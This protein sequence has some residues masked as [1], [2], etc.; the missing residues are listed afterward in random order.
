MRY[1]TKL[2]Y[3]TN[4]VFPPLE[5][6]KPF[7]E[8]DDPV[9]D[10]R[11]RGY[12]F[13]PGLL[14]RDEVLDVRHQ[15]M[16]IA[17]DAG[18]LDPTAPF[19]KGVSGPRVI[20]EHSAPEEYFDAYR[21]VQANES[22]H[23]LG[24][25]QTLVDTIT[26][27]A[28]QPAIPLPLKMARYTF[29]TSMEGASAT[30]QHQDYFYVQG[31]PDLMIAWVSLGD[32]VGKGSGRLAVLSGSPRLGLW[33]ADWREDLDPSVDVG[34][35]TGDFKAGDVLI[36]HCLT[37]HMSEPND[38]DTIRLSVDYRFQPVDDPFV[39][40]SLRP[41]YDIAS[42]DELYEGWSGRAPQH[43]WEDLNLSV[44]ERIDDLGAHRGTVKPRLITG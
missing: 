5:T 41:H 25:D 35:R 27:I 20:G 39:P 15:L 14:D 21:K 36:F 11:R 16:K 31:S 29:P 38:R 17:G 32:L 18:W 37:V 19:D 28:G 22:F 12:V 26:A 6:A 24:H 9:A 3:P 10:F 8:V 4:Q 44:I 30:P 40:T 13:L 33:G 43:Y 7:D 34:W 1:P 2:E 23:A 42:W